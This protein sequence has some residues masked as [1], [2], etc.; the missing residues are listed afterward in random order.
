[1]YLLPL[2]ADEPFKRVFSDERIAKAFIEDMLDVEITEITKLDTDHRITNQAALVR[3]DYRCKINGQYVIIEMQQGYKQNVVK[4]FFLYHCLGTALQLETLPETVHTDKKGKEHRTRHYEELQSTI[5]FVWS[6]H[7]NFNLE[8]DYIEYNP[9]PRAWMDFLKNESLWQQP[10]NVLKAHRDEL[11]EML[12]KDR[13]SLDFLA[14]NRLFFIFQPNI[15]K[16]RKALRYVKWFEFAEKTRNPN[17]TEADFAP[18]SDNLIFSN[19]MDRLA[20]SHADNQD[21]IKEMGLERY[22]AAK[23]LGQEV[24]E[25]ERQFF[26]YWKVYD[27]IAAETKLEFADQLKAA[28]QEVWNAIELSEESV[29]KAELAEKRA[30]TMERLRDKEKKAAEELLE[31]TLEK[32]KL[33]NQKLLEKQKQEAQKL[34]EKEKQEAQKLLEKEKQEAQKLLEKEKQEARKLLEKTLEKEKQAAQKLLAKEKQ[35]ARKKEEKQAKLLFQQQQIELIN[36]LLAAGMPI[37][38]IA[39]SMK[40][41]VPQI[42][43]LKNLKK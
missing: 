9:Y 22:Q 13:R 6:V 8:M 41:A 35:A 39:K 29:L 25:R 37:D 18:Y 30:Q 3:F 40:M 7:D 14:E 17:N 43:I 26:L 20:V 32:E 4:R 23:K 11:L 28:K 27:Q 34:L 31:K 24:D 16:N 12:E 33:A 36:N 1:M 10:K 5:T 38:V 42:E 19:I 15:I 2:N 21:L